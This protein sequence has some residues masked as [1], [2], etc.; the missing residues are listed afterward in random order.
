MKITA[1]NKMVGNQIAAEMDKIVTSTEHIKLFSKASADK[2]CSCSG[3]CSEKCSCAG[4]CSSKCDCLKSEAGI[5]SL[6]SDLLRWSSELESCG[7]TKSAALPLDLAEEIMS[8]D[9]EID[10]DGHSSRLKIKIENTDS[11][12]NS[13]LVLTD[14]V[15]GA[16]NDQSIMGSNWEVSDGTL[17][18]AL[19]S[20][21]E[22]LIEKLEASGYDVD[23]SEYSPMD[24][25]SFEDDE[26]LDDVGDVRLSDILNPD[27]NAIDPENH[28]SL[29]DFSMEKEFGE[30]ENDPD[31]INAQ[32]FPGLYLGLENR[33]P[34]KKERQMAE[35]DAYM[36]RFDNPEEGHRKPPRGKIHKKKLLDHLPSGHKSITDDVD[37]IT[38]Y[39]SSVSD[40]EDELSAWDNAT[41]E[42]R[43]KYTSVG[44]Y[45]LFYVHMGEAIC[46]DCANRSK[47]YS[48]IE[49]P[50][51]INWEN[52]NLHCDECGDRIESAYAEEEKEEGEDDILSDLG[53]DDDGMPTLDELL[54]HQQKLYH[55]A[56]KYLRE[57]KDIPEQMSL[58]ID[59]VEQSIN[60]MKSKKKVFKHYD[61]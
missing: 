48:D 31:F 36:S 50:S 57:G 58:E 55:A 19:I 15:V 60:Q 32:E 23:A 59:L 40:L 39:D 34:D 12:P 47:E 24:H 37:E 26:D 29:S 20:D 5:E 2:C 51:D 11:D 4:D 13:V 35:L 14:D 21:E 3:T 28:E 38:S 1:M 33:R 30:L 16:E 45:P 43:S 52:P 41:K 49:M 6:S 9:E 53:N 18:Y 17:A 27:T 44:G 22:G 10:T 7:L 46:P 42:K 54:A 61:D 25:S 8:D 56:K